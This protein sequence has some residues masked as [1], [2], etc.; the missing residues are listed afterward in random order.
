MSNQHKRITIIGAGTIGTALG[1][2]LAESGQ[3]DILL[4]SIEQQVVED[5]NR[6]HINSKYFPTLKLHPN[7][8]ATTD[9]KML[10][11]SKIIFLAIPSVVMIDY[12]KKLQIHLRPDTI[13]INLAK[14]FGVGNR[15]ILEG[16]KEQFPN[17]LCTMKGPSFAREILNR[18][19]TGFTLGYQDPDHIL[20]VRTLFRNTNIHLDFSDDIRGVEILSILKNIY[21]VVMGIVDA[22]FNSPNLRFLILTKAFQE[23][24]KVLLSFGGRSDTLF[25]YCGIGDFTLTS[26]NDLSRNRTLGLLIG[27]GFFT[28]HVSHELVLEGKTAANVFYQEISKTMVVEDHFPIIAEL[29]RIFQSNYDISLFVNKILEFPGSCPARDLDCLTK[30]D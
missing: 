11:S 13:L 20:I 5:I 26:L 14:G 23:M 1:N 19:P 4:H 29:Y 10:E 15:T 2:I 17:P 24:R 7:L 25:N 27:K 28:E 12:L 3:D 8:F 6:S 21:A 30:H 22:Q 18:S 16:L 9:D